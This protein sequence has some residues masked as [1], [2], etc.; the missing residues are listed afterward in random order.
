MRLVHKSCGSGHFTVGG[1]DNDLRNALAIGSDGVHREQSQALSV[2]S[3]AGV[4]LKT[5][6]KCGSGQL[7]PATDGLGQEGDREGELVS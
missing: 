4:S 7:G 1:A 2:A 5:Q 3:R 6:D